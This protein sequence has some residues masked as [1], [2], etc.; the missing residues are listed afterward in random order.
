MAFNLNSIKTTQTKQVEVKKVSQIPLVIKTEP[1]EVSVNHKSNLY[2]LLK[3][4]N[5][6]SK[7]DCVELTV[8]IYNYYANYGIK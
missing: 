1:K 2:N 4:S 6:L 7:E 3:N 8:E 5:K